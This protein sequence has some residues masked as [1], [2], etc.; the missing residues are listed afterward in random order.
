MGF[1]GHDFRGHPKYTLLSAFSFQVLLPE[2]FIHFFKMSGFGIFFEVKS[3][4]SDRSHGA[5]WCG[6]WMSS[7][8][9]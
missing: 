4:C 8:T 5:T 2:L 9:D 1:R 6:S 3:N 7:V